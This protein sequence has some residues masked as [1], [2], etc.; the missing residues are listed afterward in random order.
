M[1][2]I[3]ASLLLLGA[4][5]GA[6]AQIDT[7][8]RELIQLGYNQPLIGKGPLAA[9]AFY[10]LNKPN[11]FD[12]TNLTL[13]LALAPVYLDSELGI[14]QALGPHTDLGIGVAGGG[15]ADGYSEVRGG[16]YKEDE[17]FL[18]HG[19][20]LS[21]SVYHLFNPGARIPLH[22]VL[23]GAAHFTA[24]GDDT[25]TANDFV[26]PDDQ[27]SFRFRM[28]LRWGGR[29]PLM[30]PD[31]AMEL[32]VWYEGEFRGEPGRYGYSGDRTLE[33]ESHNVWARALLTYTLPECK[34][35][36]GVNLTTGAGSD[37]DR[38]SAYRLGGNLPLYSEFPLS[39]PG[40][41]FQEISARSFVLLGGNYNLPLDPKQNWWITGSAA[42]AYVDYLKGLEQPRRWNSGVGAGAVYRSPTDSWQVALAYG[43]G[44]D[45]IRSHG[46]GAH[47]LAILVQ[48]DLDSAK[49]RFF[50]PTDN[51]DRSRGLQSI[52]RSIFR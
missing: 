45:A 7:T 15:F 33:R 13:R 28:G 20:E 27:P 1:R 43:Y 8:K 18:G 31:L 12:H 34:H 46:R 22:A 3:L 29:E 14:S 48:F 51:I 24:F 32:S 26:V 5:I 42:T 11:Y 9:Y 39:L 40:Y 44:I 47:S 50:D 49:R 21:A 41:Y 37:M 10:Y 35:N 38:L 6:F 19:G 52:M 23:R 17:S 30:L 36:F 16:K 25:Q 2:T 4:T